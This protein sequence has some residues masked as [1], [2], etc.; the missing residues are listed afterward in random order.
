[1]RSTPRDSIQRRGKSLGLPQGVANVILADLGVGLQAG[2]HR[3]VARTPSQLGRLPA[4][5]TNACGRRRAV[6]LGCQRVGT[7]VA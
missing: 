2:P 3:A 1:M 5:R 7:C 6:C 4:T